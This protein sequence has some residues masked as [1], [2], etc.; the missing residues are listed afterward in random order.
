MKKHNKHEVDETRAHKDITMVSNS[1]PGE[2]GED[3]AEQIQI[4]RCS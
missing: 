3:K 4:R 1:R 2:G